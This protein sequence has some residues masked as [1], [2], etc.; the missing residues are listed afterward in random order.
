MTTTLAQSGLS[1]KD[2]KKVKRLNLLLYGPYK[3]WKTVTAHQLPRTR[4]IDFDNGMQ[5]VEWAILAGVL[6]RR[7]EDVVYET[8]V[9]DRP[10]RYGVVERINV[11]IDQVDEWV[12]E[13][14]IPP[15]DWDKPYPQQWDTLIIDSATFMVDSAIDMAVKENKRLGLS[16]SSK[17]A[18]KGLRKGQRLFVQPMVQQDWGAARQ[19]FGD[20]M[21]QWLQ[22]GKNVV[23]LAH[24]RVETDDNG[25]VLAYVPNFIGQDRSKIPAMFDEVWYSMNIP[26]SNNKVASVEFRTQQE[27]KRPLGSRL[28]C[29]DPREPADFP[30]IKEK[31]CKFYKVPPE[32]V[33]TAYHGQEGRDKAEQ[34]ARQDREAV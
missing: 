10:S 15:D 20:A 21:M 33:W 16:E 1:A 32:R 2:S 24:E 26:G 7:M 14:D 34:E 12:E 13:E 6:D 23:L 17:K 30:A 19:L 28:G 9:A 22:L 4:T 25:T 18:E 3:S 29:L 5:S 8:I 11:A 31:V 27:Y